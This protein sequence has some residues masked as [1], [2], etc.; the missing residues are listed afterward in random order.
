MVSYFS[1]HIQVSTM[2]SLAFLTDGP[3]V[4]TNPSLPWML[5][6]SVLA[7]QQETYLEH[8]LLSLTMLVCSM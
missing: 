1:F 5:S 3:I 6:L 4:Q 7:K 8:H 2:S